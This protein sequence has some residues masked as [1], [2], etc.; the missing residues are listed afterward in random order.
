MGVRK[1]VQLDDIVQSKTLVGLVLQRAD[2]RGHMPFLTARTD[3]T[4]QPISYAEAARQ[5]CL[6]AE[7]LVRL[8]LQPGDRVML[9]SENRPEW[10]IAD[11]AIM[12]AG[13]I[14]TPA[15]LPLAPL[16][17]R[18]H[19]APLPLETSALSSTQYACRE[20]RG[21]AATLS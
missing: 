6:L 1:A 21:R 9:V 7:N 10:C 15:Y 20:F 5:V 2:E 17:T 4:W 12:A 14:T 19:P 8:G 11:L 16:I 3:G 18:P 13:C